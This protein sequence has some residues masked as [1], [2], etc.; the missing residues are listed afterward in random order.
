[1]KALIIFGIA[2][3][4]MTLGSI[5]DDASE[6]SVSTLTVRSAAAIPHCDGNDGIH[7]RYVEVNSSFGELW[8]AGDNQSEIEAYY[9]GKC[10]QDCASAASTICGPSPCTGMMTRAGAH[11]QGNWCGVEFECIRCNCPVDCWCGGGGEF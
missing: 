10:V 9:R 1:M 6:T 8:D 3:G 5:G 2:I 7:V 11:W 4:V